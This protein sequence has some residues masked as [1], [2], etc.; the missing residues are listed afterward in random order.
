MDVKL[1]PPN[2]PSDPYATGGLPG[3]GSARGGQLALLETRRGLIAINPQS[4][5]RV[6]LADADAG[7]AYTVQRDTVELRGSLLAPAPGQS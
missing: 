2:M 4:V 5:V 7:R 3:A 6:D 1:A